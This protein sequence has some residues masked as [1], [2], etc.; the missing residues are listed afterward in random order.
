VS[1]HFAGVA[2]SFELLGRGEEA[3]FARNFAK[4]CLTLPTLEPQDDEAPESACSGSAC[5]L[6]AA[7]IELSKPRDA[8]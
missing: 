2:D 8:S 5:E 3:D 7:G 6:K 1:D 4:Y